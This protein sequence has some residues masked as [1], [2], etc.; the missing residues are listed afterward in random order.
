MPPTRDGA[1]AEGGGRGAEDGGERT[2]PDESAGETTEG[3]LEPAQSRLCED[4][5]IPLAAAS[6]I[7]IRVATNNNHRTAAA[8]FVQFT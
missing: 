3:A 4:T 6:Y 7:I 2:S 5:K 1:A 8:T